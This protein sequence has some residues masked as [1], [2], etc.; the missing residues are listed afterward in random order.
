MFQFDHDKF[1]NE[2]RLNLGPLSQSQVDGLTFLLGKVEQD[3]GNWQ[4][5]SQLAYGFATFMWESARHFTP[6]TEFGSPSYFENITPALRSV[7][8]S[9]IPNLATATNSAAG[10]TFKITGRVNYDRIG[11]APER[12]SRKHAGQSSRS[13]DR[14]PDCRTKACDAAGSRGETWRASFRATTRRSSNLPARS[15]MGWITQPISPQSPLRCCVLYVIHWFRQQHQS[16]TEA[17]IA[18]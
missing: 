12:R 7:K 17:P 14:V 16:L 3:S 11:K 9:A 13:G 5:L 1:F 2:F 10:A 6:I 15:S 4:N 8:I 18:S